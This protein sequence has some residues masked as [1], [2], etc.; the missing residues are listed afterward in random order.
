MFVLVSPDRIEK[1]IFCLKL[2]KAAGEESST[3]VKGPWQPCARSG[4][5]LLT[6]ERQLSEEDFFT[7]Q[8]KIPAANTRLKVDR[9]VVKTDEEAAHSFS[10]SESEF[11]EDDEEFGTHL[12]HGDD[13]PS[14]TAPPVLHLSQVRSRPKTEALD[15]ADALPVEAMST[16]VL[17]RQGSSSHTS[18]PVP[19]AQQNRAEYY[20]SL[21]LRM[22]FQEDEAKQALQLTKYSGV[23]NAVTAIVQQRVGNSPPPRVASAPSLAWLSS[24]RDESSKMDGK[25]SEIE[26]MLKPELR[27]AR[28]LEHER[29]RQAMVQGV[30]ANFQRQWS[31][32]ALKGFDGLAEGPPKPPLPLPP[33]DTDSSSKA[34][35]RGGQALA[36]TEAA[37]AAVPLGNGLHG[38]ATTHSPTN[39]A[40]NALAS[41]SSSSSSSSTE[42]LPSSSSSS[43][44]PEADSSASSASAAASSSS[45]ATS[46]TSPYKGLGLM[47]PLSQPLLTADFL[48][49]LPPDP[50]GPPPGPDAAADACD[51]PGGEGKHSPYHSRSHS[52]HNG[53]Q[54]GPGPSPRDQEHEAL[55]EQKQP[56]SVSG[57]AELKRP[58][59]KF[60]SP[61][62]AAARALLQKGPW[63]CVYCEYVNLPYHR[64]CNQCAS[65]QYVSWMLLSEEEWQEKVSTDADRARVAEQQDQAFQ[66]EWLAMV[67]KGGDVQCAVCFD[68]IV[69]KKMIPAAC[70]H[71]F[72]KDC[73]Q[74][75]LE[76]KV[77]DGNVLKIKCMYPDCPR[78]VERKEVHA[79]VS[80]EMFE[81][82]KKF[83]YDALMAT[84]PN[85]RWCPTPDC[86]MV[87][88]GV[89]SRP[90][91]TCP[92][93]H[94]AICF[95]CNLP[96]H[97]GQHSS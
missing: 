81:K 21:L 14:R 71:Y 66:E 16:P 90:K 29:E 62:V 24:Q 68:D 78:L 2:P 74:G 38:G 40:A 61:Q 8:E 31:E 18:R 46:S 65:Q 4:D 6:M 57:P 54:L 56:I 79:R 64:S 48:L 55:D 7:S 5:L 88:V 97:L 15:E 84:N 13:E 89:K 37:A 94:K 52:L 42:P 49:M 86:E 36:S 35:G 39:A 91:L 34:A 75:Y 33:L 95:N 43:S 73:W 23:E 72:C 45:S 17:V 27:R 76:S 69:V 26:S 70:R 67:A 10:S 85:A 11:L 47:T 82:Y 28:S 93:C 3:D 77:V 25:M 12:A 63:P 59:K 53:S 32:E 22:G 92:K 19:F 44:P 1:R 20:L 80:P 41:S 58:R 30:F 87:M 60:Y 83:H 50:S 9:S 51:W 96:W